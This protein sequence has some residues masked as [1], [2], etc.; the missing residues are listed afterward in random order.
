MVRS[1]VALDRCARWQD[2]GS[3]KSFLTMQLHDRKLSE[4]L[5]PRNN[6]EQ[7]SIEEECKVFLGEGRKG[8]HFLCMHLLVLYAGS[9]EPLR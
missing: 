6:D 3:L 8:P 4:H 7:A 1:E 9:N 5:I 2:D